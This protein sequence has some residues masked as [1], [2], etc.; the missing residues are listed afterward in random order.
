MHWCRKK[1]AWQHSWVVE[2]CCAGAFVTTCV[3][4]Q[5]KLQSEKQAVIE[6]V[7]EN[8]LCEFND[9]NEMLKQ[10][11]D[12]VNEIDGKIAAM[13]EELESILSSVESLT[14]SEVKSEEEIADMT[15][16]Q[17]QKIETRYGPG[18]FSQDKKHI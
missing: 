9:R 8:L 3:C 12:K 14:A 5:V 6:E 15:E 13:Q 7:V 2:K 4:L 1:C 18:S 10:E 11:S 16:E 17:R